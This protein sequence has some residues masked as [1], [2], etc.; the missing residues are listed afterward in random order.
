MH[1]A[2][3]T[4]TAGSV[5]LWAVAPTEHWRPQIITQGLSSQEGRAR[6]T[7]GSFG[8]VGKPLSTTMAS[9]KPTF[10]PEGVKAAAARTTLL[11]L[12]DQKRRKHLNYAGLGDKPGLGEEA[13]CREAVWGLML[14][15]WHHK[16][17]LSLSGRSSTPGAPST[18]KQ[19]P[20]TA[21]NRGVLLT[22]S[23]KH[24]N[25]PKSSASIQKHCNSPAARSST[26]AVCAPAPSRNRNFYLSST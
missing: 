8:Q 5:W 21:R 16:C 13:R 25:C 11:V 4:G 6:K 9:S 14:L 10:L 3:A 24:E 22:G 19:H 18:S 17:P 7:R 15:W 23:P 1:A 20:T 26:P 12:A 2:V